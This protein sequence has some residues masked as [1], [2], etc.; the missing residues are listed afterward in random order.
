MNKFLSF[1]F[2]LKWAHISIFIELGNMYVWAVKRILIRDNLFWFVQ[3]HSM[4]IN[5][6]GISLSEPNHIYIYSES[7]GYRERKRESV[8]VCHT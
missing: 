5:Q 1:V 8:F 4:L 6:Q 3:V 7:E 2:F